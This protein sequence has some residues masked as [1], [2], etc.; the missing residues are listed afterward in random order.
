VDE[1]L[2]TLL[3]ALERMDSLAV[4]DR[5]A[6]LDA[7]AAELPRLTRLSEDEWEVKLAE[8]EDD[9]ARLGEQAAR[10]AARH[11]QALRALETL[12]RLAAR[13]AEARRSDDTPHEAAAA[14]PRPPRNDVVAEIALAETTREA[15]LRVMAR[16]PHHRWTVL[17]VTEDLLRHGR[18]VE[19][20]NVQVTLRRLANAEKVTK[21]GRGAY[22]VVPEA[23]PALKG[24]PR[25]KWA[26]VAEDAADAFLRA[27]PDEAEREQLIE[28]A[29]KA[30]GTYV[31]NH[32][33]HEP[34][35]GEPVIRRLM[36]SRL[37]DF[38]RRIAKGDPRLA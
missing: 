31:R 19:R 23:V 30:V 34:M 18:P 25:H 14:T 10:A 17:G 22:Y 36:K 6:A 38:H 2:S 1:T 26:H 8:V 9:V 27:H 20:S 4:S 24:S 3:T 5:V 28:E 11:E 15:I 12:T 21:D 33:G 7:L 29:L 32:D 35:E 13:A 16:R 37:Y